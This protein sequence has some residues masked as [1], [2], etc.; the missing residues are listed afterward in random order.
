MRPPQPLEFHNW[1][2][3]SDNLLVPCL[4]LLL[5]Y[6]L[7]DDFPPT[8]LPCQGSPPDS[9]SFVFGKIFLSST[10]AFVLSF[11]SDCASF[12]HSRYQ[13]YSFWSSFCSQYNLSKS[14]VFSSVRNF[15]KIIAGRTCSSQYPRTVAPRPIIWLS[16][17]AIVLA[18]PVMLPSL[19]L[20][21][22]GPSAY[23]LP[24]LSV[25]LPALLVMLFPAVVLVE[26]FWAMSWGFSATVRNRV[27]R[28]N[29]VCANIAHALRK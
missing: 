2:P 16:R 9:S 27:G 15:Y 17:L 24:H 5:T 25:V 12:S 10:K 1:P 7:S 20:S 14:S 28:I 19:L 11:T 22:F 29:W 23:P 18:W 3:E 8:S 6:P 26:L 4:V 21:F 13:S